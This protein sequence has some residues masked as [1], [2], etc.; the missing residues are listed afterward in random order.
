MLDIKFPD[1]PKGQTTSFIIFGLCI[2]FTVLAY[3]SQNNIFGYVFLGLYTS[4]NT[5]YQSKI[6]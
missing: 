1:I 6:L 3:K 5:W 4:S 2:I